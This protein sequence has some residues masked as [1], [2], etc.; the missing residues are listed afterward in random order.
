MGDW[1]GNGILQYWFADPA[2]RESVGSTSTRAAGTSGGEDGI[3]STSTSASEGSPIRDRVNRCQNERR[4]A[5]LSALVADEP[6]VRL[7]GLQPAPRHG[8]A[9]TYGNWDAGSSASRSALE[10]PR[11]RAN[12]GQNAPRS[13]PVADEPL[14]RPAGLQH[15]VVFGGSNPRH[16][17]P[18]QAQD[19]GTRPQLQ[20][21]ASVGASV[22]Q[23]QLQITCMEELLAAAGIRP[24]GER[25]GAAG[26]GGRPAAQLGL[27]GLQWPPP[28]V[29]PHDQRAPRPQQHPQLAPPVD[30]S[31]QQLRLQ[32]RRMAEALGDA[33]FRPRPVRERGGAAGGRPAAQLGLPGLQRPPQ[34]QPV[35]HA[36]NAQ[37][38]LLG[39]QRPPQAQPVPHAGNAQFGFPGLIQ[40]P[41]RAPVRLHYQ[42]VVF[43]PGPD[44]E[45]DD[46]WC[47]ACGDY[48]ARP[49][50]QPRRHDCVCVVCRY[51]DRIV[52]PVCAF[53]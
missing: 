13:V 48:P 28:Q 27:L 29:H 6:R 46:G 47:P 5:W 15:G 19:S 43:G 52:C 9:E 42:P 38:G 14:F 33:G 22:Q 37:L 30:A 39:L 31:E 20:I 3:G 10:V 16:G 50:L 32:L 17:L 1:N 8:G 23:L 26:A 4:N 34:A 2:A 44:H 35:P 41:P 21:G 53:W 51:V 12:P 49:L 11:V 7:A 36:G 25:G 45:L 40:R 18:G 24:V